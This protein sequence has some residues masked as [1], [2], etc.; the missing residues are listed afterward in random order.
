MNNKWT[1][2]S[3]VHT[4][5]GWLA[6]PK[7]FRIGKTPHLLAWQK[8]CRCSLWRRQWLLRTVLWLQCVPTRWLSLR[9]DS[10]NSELREMQRRLYPQCLLH[11]YR[12]S[13][14]RVGS[15]TSRWLPR[16]LTET[17]ACLP[18]AYRQA[19]RW[20]SEGQCSALR[21]QLKYLLS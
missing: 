2:R 19:C 12:R 1:W 6:W 15:A 21:P 17:A 18:K 9:S 4:E 5:R 20:W 11:Y 13:A 3:H 10:R 14:T 16:F 7:C 8:M